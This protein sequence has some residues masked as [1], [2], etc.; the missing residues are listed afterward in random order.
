MLALNLTSD[1]FHTPD[2]TSFRFRNKVSKK[3]Q[4][5]GKRGCREEEK[6][7][8]LTSKLHFILASTLNG[9]LPRYQGLQGRAVTN[10][11][12]RGQDL[13]NAIIGKHGDLVYVPE[14][15]IALAVEASPKVGD[16]DLRAFQEP[17]WFPSTF[18]WEFISETDK[19]PRKE[20]D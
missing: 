20:V 13:R 15:A 7:S 3:K 16:H 12:E 18:E 1:E 17:D 2:A 10:T 8:C 5:R 6:L 4:S 14:S 19:V 11:T 9:L